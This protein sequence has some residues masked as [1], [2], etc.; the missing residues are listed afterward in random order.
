[1]DNTDSKEWII[2]GISSIEKKNHQ[3][4]AVY[5]YIERE[6]ERVKAKDLFQKSKINK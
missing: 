2:E 1:M 5:I 4:Y 3:N 6:R